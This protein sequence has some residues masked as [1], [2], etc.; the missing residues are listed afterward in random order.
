VTWRVPGWQANTYDDPYIAVSK[1]GQVYAS[2]PARNLI[3]AT[4]MR[5]DVVMRWGGKGGD[6]AS[7]TLPS[8]TAV[9]P[10]GTIYIVDR[11]NNRAMQFKM[12]LLGR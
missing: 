6:L 7:L 1:D 8:G 5:G 11:G 3:L 4:S 12:P 10:D 9:G 2:V